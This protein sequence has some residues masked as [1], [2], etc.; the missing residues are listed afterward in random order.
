MLLTQR[1]LAFSISRAASGSTFNYSDEENRQDNH[2]HDEL[3]H[4]WIIPRWM[5]AVA[6]CVLSST[7]SLLRMLLT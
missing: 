3:S 7:P 2:Q 4:K 6:A 1:R 5:A